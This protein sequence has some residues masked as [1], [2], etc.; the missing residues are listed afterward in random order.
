ME[1]SGRLPFKVLE[2]C[3]ILAKYASSLDPRSHPE[4]PSSSLSL[5]T[6]VLVGHYENNSLT[7]TVVFPNPIFK[8]PSNSLWHNSHDDGK[9]MKSMKFILPLWSPQ[10]KQKIRKTNKKQTKQTTIFH[11]IAVQ[12]RTC[13]LLVTYHKLTLEVQ[14]THQQQNSYLQGAQIVRRTQV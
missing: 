4:P 13:R 12:T 9:L 7:V 11:A 2:Q 14:A 5:L 6:Y 3:L 8:K 10:N 1:V